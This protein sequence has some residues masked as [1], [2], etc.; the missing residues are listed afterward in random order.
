M[1]DFIPAPQ[2][3]GSWRS[4]MSA[5]IT[6]PSKASAQ[7][8]G[9]RV[10]AF[11]PHVKKTMHSTSPTLDLFEH[12]VSPELFDPGDG[13]EP[14]FESDPPAPK[15]NGGAA[16]PMVIGLGLLAVAGAAWYFLR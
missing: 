5:P 10:A 6:A 11:L 2:R 15:A 16:S 7:A 4:L 13:V 1:S 3:F 12:E 9:S 8:T 14:F